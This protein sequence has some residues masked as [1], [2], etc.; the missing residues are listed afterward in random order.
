MGVCTSPFTIAPKI[1]MQARRSAQIE[2]NRCPRH[3]DD[4]PLR[5]PLRQR[6][7][8]HVCPLRSEDCELKSQNK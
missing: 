4:E 6:G 3:S 2:R 5:R 7:G 1:P 8:S